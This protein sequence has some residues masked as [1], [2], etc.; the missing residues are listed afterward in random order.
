MLVLVL[1]V[2]PV[3]VFFVECISSAGANKYIDHSSSK[4]TSR[5]SRSN[6][7]SAAAL[8]VL[9]VLRSRSIRGCDNTLCC[10]WVLHVSGTS[11]RQTGTCP[12]S[13]THAWHENASASQCSISH[14]IMKANLEASSRRPSSN[15]TI[16]YG[17]SNGSGCVSAS[18]RLC[19]NRLLAGAVAIESSS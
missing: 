11:F 10:L 14:G 16:S 9:V 5:C 12:Q 6:T 3:V 18:N 13:L 4:Q 2:V 7:C 17:S 8:V 15:S 1:V 19:C